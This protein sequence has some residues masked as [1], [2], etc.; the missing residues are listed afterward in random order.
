MCDGIQILS[1]YVDGMAYDCMIFALTI[2]EL[3]V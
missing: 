2:L 1:T 3:D